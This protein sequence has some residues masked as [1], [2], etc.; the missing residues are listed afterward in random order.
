LK[1]K[2]IVLL[3]FAMIMLAI[4]GEAQV[5]KPK[6]RRVAQRMPDNYIV[7]FKDTVST[8]DVPSIAR[9]IASAHNSVARFIYQYALK[10]FA[11]QVSEADAI[12]I[13]N[14]S[15]VEW[16]EEDAVG[17]IV[18]QWGLDRI[19][20]RYLPLDNVYSFWQLAAN[21]NIYVLDTGIRAT[22]SEFGGRVV[23]AFDAV[24]ANCYCGFTCDNAFAATRGHGTA[25]ASVA[26]GATYGV[27]RNATLYDVRVV[28]C[29]GGVDSAKLISGINWVTQNFVGPAVANISSAI[30]AN[31]SVDTAVRNS[32]AAGV[33]Y[34]VGAGNDSTD[35]IGYSPARMAD[36]EVLTVGA[37][38]IVDRRG[39]DW[40][41]QN[42]IKGSN[43]GSVVDIFAPGTNITVAWS[44]SDSDT[45][46]GINGTSLA[47]P[48]VAGV[49]AHYKQQ[50]PGASPTTVANW[51]IGIATSGVVTDQRP[52]GW[53]LGI[54]QVHPGTPNRLLFQPFSF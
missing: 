28:N 27:I 3:L 1:I 4:V 38:D 10:G 51:I 26:S 39:H 34:V 50:H 19:D 22:H 24:Q 6:F 41:P 14:D 16:V 15:R 44:D 31:D 23:S 48:Y 42:P 5:P 32:A 17:S 18:E 2:V 43:W 46:T 36:I 47:S 35:A 8:A 33:L 12:E 29:D 25:V 20:Q 54:D 9:Q 37:T 30:A 7:V 40:D 49:A 45:R 53:I 13:S 21:V 11:V 52:D